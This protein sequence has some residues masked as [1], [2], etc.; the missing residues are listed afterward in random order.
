MAE[1]KLGNIKTIEEL[2]ARAFAYGKFVFRRDESMFR[3]FIGEYKSH[4]DL[5]ER[6]SLLKKGENSFSHIWGGGEFEVLDRTLTFSGS[7][8]N[9]GQVPNSFLIDCCRKVRIPNINTFVFSLSPYSLADTLLEERRQTWRD[10]GGYELDTERK[11]Y[12]FDK[13]MKLKS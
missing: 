6:L 7:S 8:G 11:R 13:D 2:T 4:P 1:F 3:L 5:V 10:L 12:A 9:Y